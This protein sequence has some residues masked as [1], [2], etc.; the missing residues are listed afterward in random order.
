MQPPERKPFRILS[1]DGGGVRAVLQ[2]IILKRLMAESPG[3]LDQIDMFAGT[4]AGAITATALATG[5][6]PDDV[7]SMWQGLASK[8]FS[9]RFLTRMARLDNCIGAPYSNVPLRQALEER[10]GTRT[11][12]DVNRRLFIPSFKLDTLVGPDGTQRRWGPTFFHN[13]DGSQSAD[14]TLVDVLLRTS[15]APTYFP[16]YQG[17]IDG[18]VFAN[19]PAM[20]A[21][22]AALS[23]GVALQ[24][25]VVLSIST[26]YR[27]KSINAH[28]IGNGNWGLYDWG[29]QIVDLLFDSSV[30]CTDYQVLS[31]LGDRYQRI[32]PLL[33]VNYGLDQ[34]SAIPQLEKLG[35]SVD[36]DAAGLWM[37]RCFEGAR[38]DGVQHDGAQH[39]GLNVTESLTAQQPTEPALDGSPLPQRPTSPAAPRQPA[40]PSVPKHMSSSS[41]SV[42]RR[43]VSPSVANRPASPFASER[44]ASPA[45]GRMDDDVTVTNGY[46]ADSVS[47]PRSPSHNGGDILNSDDVLARSWTSLQDSEEPE[48]PAS[49]GPPM[50]VP[51][52][53]DAASKRSCTIQ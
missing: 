43:P 16:I 42:P 15:A 20:S 47:L 51:D 26:G 49:L 27:P 17:Y 53:S 21:V 33:P 6:M 39:D 14:H 41:P 38:H 24:D 28:Q 30:E 45:A 37:Q 7:L 35:W 48:H 23:S 5:L 10:F 13:L 25:I 9:E 1:L 31:L 40:S 3:L 4:S 50:W 32:D 11:L 8:V 29:F 44:P 52:A 12:A 46:E 34:A 2:S 19:N 22:V 18:G 36:L